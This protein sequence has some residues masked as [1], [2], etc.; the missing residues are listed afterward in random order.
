MKEVCVGIFGGNVSGCL[1][2]KA[3]QQK[4]QAI[5]I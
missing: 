4:K 5:V 2:Y 1:K 3:L